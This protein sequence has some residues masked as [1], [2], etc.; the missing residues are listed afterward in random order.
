MSSSF[1]KNAEKEGPGE[2]C[3]SQRTRH[4]SRQTTACGVQQG[5]FARLTQVDQGCCG[6]QNKLE[7]QVGT[8]QAKH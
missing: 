5:K 3:P 4:V 8:V 2:N 1:P 7:P 6:C